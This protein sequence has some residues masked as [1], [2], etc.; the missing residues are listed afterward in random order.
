MHQFKSNALRRTEH[1]SVYSKGRMENCTN[2][3]NQPLR[4]RVQVEEKK[5]CW[6]FLWIWTMGHKCMA[7]KF[8][9]K[10]TANEDEWHTLTHWRDTIQQC[11]EKVIIKRWISMIGL[12]NALL[13]QRTNRSV[14]FLGI[15]THIRTLSNSVSRQW[16]ERREIR[17]KNNELNVFSLWIVVWLIVS[18]VF[19]F[20]YIFQYFFS[21]FLSWKNNRQ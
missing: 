17:N 21:S 16:N 14:S 3:N 5:N 18:Y 8:R 12:R 9:K 6:K 20:V 15:K 1:L 19:R 4:A 7:P 11:S 2:G 13:A 10:N